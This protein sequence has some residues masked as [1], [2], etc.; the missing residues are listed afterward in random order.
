ME[1]RET[2]I[3]ALKRFK[4]GYKTDGFKCTLNNRDAAAYVF[5]SLGPLSLKE[6]TSILREWRPDHGMNGA[7]NLHFTYM[8]NTSR[9]GGYG[10]VGRDVA[11]KGVWMF[12]DKYTSHEIPYQDQDPESVAAARKNILYKT[13]SIFFRRQYWYR[14]K[15]G[16]YAPT[17]ECFKRMAEIG[18]LF[19]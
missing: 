16:L 19:E 7:K 1:T 3:A 8:F 17:L 9:T 6:I 4:H 12:S 18:H 2:V 13:G 5:A 14:A 15:P 10:C 11:A